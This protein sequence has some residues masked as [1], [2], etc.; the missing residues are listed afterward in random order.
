M[1]WREH[2]ACWFEVL[3]PRPCLARAVELIAATGAVELDAEETMR[4]PELDLADVEEDLAEYQRL[5]RAYAEHWPAPRLP[6]AG[7]SDR[8]IE[9]A[10]HEAL[11]SLRSWEA[12]AEPRVRRTERLV[13][14]R[15]DLAE[16]HD[17]LHAMDG[18]DSLDFS[19]LV[20]ARGAAVARLFLL[21]PETPTPRAARP[22]L[23]LRLDAPDQ[24]FLLL[25]G[26]GEELDRLADDL[27]A[28]GGRGVAL[29]DW[30]EGGADEALG[31][32]RE[33]LERLDDAIG[34]AREEIRECSTRHDVSGALGQVRR[35][36]WM[37]EH[38]PSVQVSDYLARITGWTD[39]DDPEGLTAPLAAADIPAVIGFPEPPADR[40]PPR[41]TRNPAW[42][43]PFELFMQLMGTPGRHETDPSRML[44]FIAPLLFGYMFGDVG[45][46]AVLIGAGILLRRRWPALG[47]LIPGG[48]VAMVFGAM[49]GSVF[50]VEGLFAPL[51][52][53]PV[54]EPLPVLVV[55]VFAGAA[56]ILLGLL[57]NGLVARRGHRFA[58][59]L[60][61]EAGIIVIYIGAFTAA[62]RPDEGFP[63]MFV[64]IAWYL[65]GCSWEWHREGAGPALGHM[66]ELL[67]RLLQL[68]VNTLSFLRVGA[69][70]LA[71]AGLS[72]AVMTLA[73]SAPNAVFMAI[74]LIVGNAAVL[75]LEGLVVSVQTT[76]LILFEF[77]IRFFQAEGRPFRPMTPPMAG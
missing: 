69:F 40:E 74:V 57:L 66:G 26:P 8:P 56:L 59:W 20:S 51:W 48:A 11:E 49:F 76:R 15:S 61:T 60:R 43:R 46:G 4:A 32:T 27:R 28:L 10:L 2:C 9:Q 5:Q 42:A 21:P 64:G 25:V 53:N 24:V 41:L 17:F 29:P 62:V 45:Q 72:M 55:P 31:I 54:D 38:L 77:F 70:A 37:F 16:V 68:A 23:R 36:Q 52:A 14:D 73:D 13:R 39:A 67:E 22:V 18:D 50:T 19:A 75:V 7:V 34:H 71:H 3:V 1:Q 63:V 44:A 47:M 33:R 6:G 35:L 58:A 30:L 12:E 65:V